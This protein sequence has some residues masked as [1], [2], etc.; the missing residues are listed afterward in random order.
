MY[1]E[2]QDRFVLKSFVII[3]TL[4]FTLASLALAQQSGEKPAPTPPSDSE[5]DESNG[6]QLIQIDEV[7]PGPVYDLIQ[8]GNRLARASRFDEAIAEYKAALDKAG[9][10]IFTIYLN[11]GAVYIQKEDY[12]S[13]IEAYRK[14]E[15]IRTD[16]RVS[17]YI[18]EV[19]FSMNEF[20]EAEAAYRK[21][22]DLTPGGINPPAHHFLGLS[23]YG[24]QRID[25][26]IA[27]YRIA[28]EQSKG[29]YAEARYNL[30]IALMARNDNKAA[31]DEFRRAIE[32][33]K[34]DWPEAHF[35]LATVLERQSS[36]REAADHYEIYLKQLPSA[37]DTGRIRKCIEWLRQQK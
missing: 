3:T 7:V 28:I 21:A 14:A 24:Q 30:G 13:A 1:S 4:T 27:E 2:K 32:Q 36:F 33:E 26:A 20:K 15:T 11:L 12:K 29:N 34:K 9:K 18:A 10:P 17:F 25:E 37:E 35:N 6:L 23:L 16:S 19:L 31:E 22:I 8:R 5:T